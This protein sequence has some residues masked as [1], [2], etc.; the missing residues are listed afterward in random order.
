MHAPEQA[1]EQKNNG[2]MGGLGMGRW[3]WGAHLFRSSFKLLPR[4][5]NPNPNPN[6]NLVVVPRT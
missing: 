2:T 4:I 3:T 6:P 5:R 1:L